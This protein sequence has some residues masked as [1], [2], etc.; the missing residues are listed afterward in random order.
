MRQ[1]LGSSD[2]PSAEL[3]EYNKEIHDL[4]AWPGRFSSWERFS[5]RN[6]AAPGLWADLCRIAGAHGQKHQRAGAL[7]DASRQ[8]GLVQ[9][10]RERLVRRTSAAFELLNHRSP[11]Y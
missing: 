5:A 11:R 6:D 7:Q 3:Y 4:T 9:I 10:A 2:I 1:V 8:P